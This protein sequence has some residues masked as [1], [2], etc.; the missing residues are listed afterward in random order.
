MQIK[1]LKLYHCPV[2]R[3]ARVKWLLHELFEEDFDVEVISL[4]DATQYRDEYLN[5]N[6]NHAV[7]VLEIYTDTGKQMRMIESG[8]IVTFLADLYPDKNLAPSAHEFSPERSDYLQ[9]L[10]F[11]TS[12][13]D[14]MLWQIRIHEHILPASEKDERTIQRYREKFTREVEPQLER[15]LA[16][17]PFICGN[18][19]SAVDCIIGHCV[20]WAQAYQLCTAPVFT[21]YVTRLAARPAFARAFSDAQQF[22]LD[23]PEEYEVKKMFTG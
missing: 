8:A 1:R 5:I 9:M 3:S 19:F 6:P 20:M 7:P 14:M 22:V 17:T 23:V 16:T 12:S 2:V 10:Q 4:Y 18:E 13:I 15:R 11:G 21:A